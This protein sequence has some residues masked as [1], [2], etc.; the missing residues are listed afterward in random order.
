VSFAKAIAFA[1]PGGL[2]LIFW[3]EE[4]ARGIRETLRDPACDSA[5]EFML[6]IGPEGGFGKDEIDQAKQTGCVSVSLGKR[7]L[8]VDTAAAVALAIL[9]YERGAIGGADRGGPHGG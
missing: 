7:I 1:P 2:A 8:R 6:V 4:A 5:R 9:Q 3:E